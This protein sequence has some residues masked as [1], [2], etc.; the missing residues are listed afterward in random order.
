MMYAA[1]RGHEEIIVRLLEKGGDVA[2]RDNKRNTALHYAALSRHEGCALKLL[3]ANTTALVNA[4]N[5]DEKMPL[6]IS[7]ERK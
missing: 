3:D 1:S 5:D 2:A 4:T 6:H 7:G